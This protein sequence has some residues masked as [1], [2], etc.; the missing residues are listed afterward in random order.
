[1]KREFKIDFFELMFLAEVCI[2]PAPI[3]RSMFFQDLTDVYYNLM[4]KN[5]RIQCYEWVGK[6]VKE[7]KQQVKDHT[8]FLSRFNPDNQY[9]VYYKHGDIEQSIKAFKM[10]D[11]FYISSNT[12]IEPKF[13]IK[14][15]KI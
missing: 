11:K 5:E 7:E 4:S 14:V 15:K 8:I 3:A 9:K 1:M 2:P 6:K 13:I 10:N 12:W